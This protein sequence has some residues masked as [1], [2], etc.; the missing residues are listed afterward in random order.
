ME[1]FA[2]L[3]PLLIQLN[4]LFSSTMLASTISLI[5]I[6]ILFR[7]FFKFIRN[8][9]DSQ[10]VVWTGLVTAKG[11]NFVSLTKVI[12]LVGGTV[13]SWIVIKLTIQE[14]LTWDI[15]SLYLTYC[16][17]TEGFSKYLTAKY[18]IPT[19]NKKEDSQ[20]PDKN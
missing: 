12:Q 10:Q 15:F 6:I 1:H 13:S 5:S 19:S 18:N 11:T 3:D 9:H 8:S 2:F 4:S 16:A 7:W 20:S 14:K 17:G